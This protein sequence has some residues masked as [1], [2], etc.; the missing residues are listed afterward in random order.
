VKG[1]AELGRSIYRERGEGALREEK[2]RQRLLQSAINGGRYSIE[3]ERKRGE[4]E[5]EG[6]MVMGANGWAAQPG[7]LGRL[8]VARA[9]WWCGRV[10]LAR[11]R[12]EGED[13]WVGPTCR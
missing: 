4:E 2:G 8:G 5:G 9:R 10:H 13:P 3:G 1:G 11:R 6:T 7:W 12:E